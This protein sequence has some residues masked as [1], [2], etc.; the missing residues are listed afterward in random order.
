MIDALVLV[1]GAFTLS[2]RRCRQLG[3]LALGLMGSV[4]AFGALSQPAV[5][6]PI[7]EGLTFACTAATLPLIGH[8]AGRLSGMRQAL[9]QQKTEL[10]QALERVNVLATRDEL[11]ALPNRRFMQDLITRE[12]PRL[13]RRDAPLC[14]AVLDLDHFKAVNDR[15][16]HAVGDKVLRTF[17]SETLT[18]LRDA[19]TLAR[20]GGEEFLLMLPD[21]P[22]DLAL[23]VIQRLHEHLRNP[24]SW[25]RCREVQVTFS[26]GL[27]VHDPTEDFHETLE[28]ADRAL[29]E[30]KRSG[31]DRCV[32]AQPARAS[33]RPMQLTLLEQDH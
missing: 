30:A 31:R 28:R 4:M 16:G 9:R 24:A 2:P 21:T 3:W 15:F 10:R 5:F 32:E 23:M 6:N 13:R 22:P 11:T 26:A 25:T 33:T 18:V 19:D 12:L 27:A 1:F 8:L 20:W 29:Y 7:V 14:I 17:A